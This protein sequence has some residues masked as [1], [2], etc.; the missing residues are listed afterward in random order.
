MAS[1]RAAPP[2]VP[3]RWRNDW[4]MDFGREA[5]LQAVCV[6][7]AREQRPKLI[8][9]GS[10]GGLHVSAP[11]ARPNPKTL[12]FYKYV[13]K[14]IGQ[15]INRRGHEAGLPDL[16]IMESGVDYQGKLISAVAVEFKVQGKH[17]S[18]EQVNMQI[19]L[20]EQGV[21]YHVVRTLE[22]FVTRVIFPLD[23]TSPLPDALELEALTP[24]QQP[25]AP[26]AAK[27]APVVV[28]VDGTVDC[29]V[30]TTH[31]VDDKGNFWEICD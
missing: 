5:D 8:L 22:Q 4:Y 16:F 19:R 31:E 9:V 1:E 6:A 17:Q 3:R 28:T 18:P 11:G 12:G 27:N 21:L 26:H 13:N 30:Q 24:L 14:M 15:I 23:V 20:E 25:V 7:W 2:A 10:P 29:D